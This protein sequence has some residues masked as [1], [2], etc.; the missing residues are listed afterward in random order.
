MKKKKRKPAGSKTSDSR[1]SS[2]VTRG[3][4]NNKKPTKT[5]KSKKAKKESDSGKK[6]DEVKVDPTGNSALISGKV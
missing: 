3:A 6:S 1:A 5:S 2:G 4:K